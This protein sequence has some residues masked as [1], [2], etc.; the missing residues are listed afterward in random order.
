MAR[1]LILLLVAGCS[2]RRNRVVPIH[3]LMWFLGRIQE[4]LAK[5]LGVV[6]TTV[7]ASTD[8]MAFAGLPI[9]RSLLSWLISVMLATVGE[10]QRSWLGR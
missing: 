7:A 3:H 10:E 9:S 1:W 6:V 5:K 4:P 2:V 8:K